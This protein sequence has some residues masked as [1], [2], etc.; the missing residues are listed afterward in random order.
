MRYTIAILLCALAA[1]GQSL[2]ALRQ[3]NAA[4]TNVLNTLRPVLGERGQHLPW[5]DDEPPQ[6]PSARPLPPGWLVA[7][8]AVQQIP[9]PMR[10][11]V[12]TFEG[13]TFST[14]GLVAEA[15]IGGRSNVFRRVIWSDKPATKDLPAD[16]GDGL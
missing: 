12:W 16:W 14:W 10:L 5:T 3:S 13:P 1:S 9:A 2:D 11:S 15:Q 8:N 4:L 7:S 6:Q